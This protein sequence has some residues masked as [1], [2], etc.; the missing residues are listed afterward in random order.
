MKQVRTLFAV[1]IAAFGTPA[2]AAD[3]VVK[4]PPPALA[5]V[6][7]WGGCYIGPNGGAAFGMNSTMTWTDIHPPP[8]GGAVQFDPINFNRS[9]TVAGIVGGQLG[10]N[11]QISPIYILGLESDASW[12]DLSNTASQNG[13]T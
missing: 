5:P 3:M 10:C 6:A 11:W 7:N 9:S 13:L 1:A 12:T 2:F 8:G 4:A